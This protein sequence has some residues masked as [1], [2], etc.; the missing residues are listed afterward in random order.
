MRHTTR[1]PTRRDP[2]PPI[3]ASRAPT[4]R[5]KAARPSS[6]TSCT[7]A[8]TR[9]D[10]QGR[11]HAVP[12]ARQRGRRDPRQRRRGGGPR[13]ADLRKQGTSQ[14]PEGPWHQGP[15]HAPAARIHAGA[16]VWQRSLSRF[17]SG[18][19]AL[20]LN[21][22]TRLCTVIATSPSWPDQSKPSA[23]RSLGQ[24]LAP[25]RPGA[26]RRRLL[27]TA[28]FWPN[29]ISKVACASQ[30]GAAT[31]GSYPVPTFACILTFWKPASV[32]AAP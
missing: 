16:A 1:P 13:R 22:R 6:A 23:Q 21:C 12:H 17:C 31:P 9:A 7:S 27:G 3:R 5:A 4:G 20:V 19:V 18:E 29:R 11:V 8:S 14:G 28:S 32:R 2:E 24:M 15:H 30:S 26:A 25:A 10:P